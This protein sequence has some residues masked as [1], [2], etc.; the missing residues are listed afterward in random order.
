MRTTCL[1]V[2]LRIGDGERPRLGAADVD[3]QIRSRTRGTEERRD[4]RQEVR[5]VDAVRGGQKVE[6]GLAR[7]RVARDSCVPAC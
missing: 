7:N 1:A 5:S 3:Q 4:E 6:L 2:C